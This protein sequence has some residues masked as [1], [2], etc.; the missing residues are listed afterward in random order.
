MQTSRSGIFCFLRSVLQI[1]LILA[2]AARMAPAQQACPPVHVTPPDPRL[3]IFTD[4]QE[5]DLGDAIA[6]QVQRDFLVIDDEDY[7]GYLQRVGK[8]LLAQAP[9]TDLKIQFFL[10]DLPVANA[11]SLP[12][13]TRLRLAQNC[14]SGQ[15]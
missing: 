13:G 12:G 3:N 14:S 6:E 15:K 2:I 10:S 8:R 4:R 1:I 7:T 11:L 9:P 5:M